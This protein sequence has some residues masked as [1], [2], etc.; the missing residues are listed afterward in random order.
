MIQNLSLF[1][2]PAIRP[3]STSAMAP[4]LAY[5]KGNHYRIAQTLEVKNSGGFGR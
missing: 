1:H 2:L 5:N 4:V 3:G